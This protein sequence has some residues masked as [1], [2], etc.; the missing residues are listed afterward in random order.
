M[1]KGNGISNTKG[2]GKYSKMEKTHLTRLYAGLYVHMYVCRSYAESS[3]EN[4]PPERPL[5]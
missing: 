4:L 1:E 5:S 2:V 3:I